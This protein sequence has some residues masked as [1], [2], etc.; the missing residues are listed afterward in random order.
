MLFDSSGNWRSKN[1][2]FQ[3]NSARKLWHRSSS[4]DIEPTIIK[5]KQAPQINTISKR[6]RYNENWRKIIKSTNP[7]LSKAW[8][9]TSWQTSYS[10]AAYSTMSWILSLLYGIC[11]I[12]NKAKILGYQW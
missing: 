11:A 10:G 12:S 5:E 1:N 6:E 8:I 2:T 3:M 4:T 7:E 9:N